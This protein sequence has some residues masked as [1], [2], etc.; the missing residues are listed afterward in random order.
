[1]ALKKQNK[2]L[3][4]FVIFTLLILGYLLFREGK[5]GTQRESLEPE[6]TESET[7]VQSQEQMGD[8]ILAV[9]GEN[10]GELDL[11]ASARV[12]TQILGD[13]A[14]C[15]EVKSSE[16]LSNSPIQIET[17]IQAFQSELG[18]VSHQA[19]R[20]MIWSLKTPEGKETRLKLEITEND[21][22]QIGKELYYF[23][24]DRDGQAEPLELDPEKANNPSD[25]IISELLKTGEVFYKERAAFALFPGAERV[26]YVE[27]EG[28]LAE[29]EFFRGEKSFRCRDLKSRESCQC[30]P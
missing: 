23:A 25:E 3:L 27:K 30:G 8:P 13:L 5:L 10:G 7:A 21:E 1:M 29:L 17:V 20:W 12:F 22:G 6:V 26:E 14:E 11:T 4:I 28:E 2:T 16:I 18:P 24:I 15:L 19:D 9:Q